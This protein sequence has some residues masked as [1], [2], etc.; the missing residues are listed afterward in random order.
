MLIIK[1]SRLKL[2]GLFTLPIVFVSGG[3][4]MAVSHDDSVDPAVGAGC[5]FFC[6][7][8]LIVLLRRLVSPREVTIS[9]DGISESTWKLGTI[10]WS[11]VNEVWLGRV[12]HTRF[13]CLALRQPDLYTPQ[14]SLAAQKLASLN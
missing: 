12:K 7:A 3:V 11:E 9:A 6:G 2:I 13:L 5:A 14:L 8:A 10:P 4:W 1:E